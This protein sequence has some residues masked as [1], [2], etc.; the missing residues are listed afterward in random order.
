[1]NKS[2]LFVLATRKTLCEFLHYSR[3]DST[4]KAYAKKFIMFEASDYEIMS[5]VVTGDYPT[6]KYN[7][8]KEEKL[9]NQYKNTILENLSEIA[10]YIEESILRNVITEVSPI[11][12]SSNRLLK[13]YLK[14]QKSEEEKSEKVKG[15]ATMAGAGIVGGFFSSAGKNAYSF[16][17]EKAKIGLAPLLSYLKTPNGKKV[18][19]AVAASL[20]IFA[21]IVIYDKYFSETGRS[22]GRL[23]GS[24]R[25]Q[26][27]KKIKINAIQ[28]QIKALNQGR[29]ACSNKD[30]Q[31]KC[32]QVI[33]TK[34]VKLQIKLSKL[35]N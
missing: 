29:A 17:K 14:E 1:M 2:I 7:P 13:T 20:I 34:I 28:N 35:G 23:K 6:E 3:L 33:K 4:A 30:N 9:F 22:C 16:A 11:R 26:C 31:N 10:P 19:A 12:S 24:E 21:S 8:L 18:G 15:F 5:L 32:D 27:I 25:D